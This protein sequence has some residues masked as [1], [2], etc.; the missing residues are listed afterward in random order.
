MKASS[1]QS[2]NRRALDQ[3][4]IVHEA[5][6]KLALRWKVAVIH[7]I[8]SGHTTYSHLKRALPGVTDQVLA[9]RLR[10][11]VREGLVVKSNGTSEAAAPANRRS[12][13]ASSAT[14]SLAPSG[15]EALLIAEQICRWAKKSNALTR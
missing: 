8:A 9:R 3:Q 12:T 13:S 10:E 14:Y 11:L 15:H 6:A 7:S 1:T 2:H 5:L 4:C